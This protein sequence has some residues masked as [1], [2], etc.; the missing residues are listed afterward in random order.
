MKKTAP[1][2]D[3]RM[4]KERLVQT[5]EREGF[6]VLPRTWA[7]GESLSVTLQRWVDESDSVSIYER[8]AYLSPIPNWEVPLTWSVLLLGGGAGAETR[9]ESL[10]DATEKIRNFL[11]EA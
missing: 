11:L 2:R 3:C 1:T 9:S 4:T 8:L 7:M 5:L 10:A 6:I